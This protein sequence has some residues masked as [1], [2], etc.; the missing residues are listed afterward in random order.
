M[1]R[2]AHLAAVTVCGTNLAAAEPLRQVIPYSGY[3]DSDG[4]PYDGA[5]QLRFRLYDVPQGAQ[6]EG[7]P[8]EE[9]HPAVQVHQG[10]FTVRL[11]D[12]RG[13]NAVPQPVAPLLA[14]NR[15]YWL[16][17]SV[18]VVDGDC[19]A[20]GAWTTLAGRQQVSPAPQAVWSANA[21]D[22][23]LQ[24]L[25]VQGATHL[26]GGATVAG[27]GLTVEGPSTFGGAATVD[28]N[29]TVNGSTTLNGNTT[30][31]DRTTTRLLTV[32]EGATVSGAVIARQF[33]IGANPGTPR[34]LNVFNVER[35]VCG[36][37][38]WVEDDFFEPC[39]RPY[40]NRVCFLSYVSTRDGGDVSDVATCYVRLQGANWNLAIN[41]EADAS[42]RCDMTCL[43]W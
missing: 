35:D 1:K 19:G 10:A 34:L 32:N 8:W 4:Q 31:R 23:R 38:N 15:Q 24:T 9:C 36:H 43:S 28:G 29:A 37:A 14:M 27:T 33:A 18:R 5:V 17:L 7:Q 42:V 3:L 39:T 16:E 12:A 40:A 2:L 26:G 25:D 13:P 22:L 30:V 21:T 6:A 41:A 11:G 20:P